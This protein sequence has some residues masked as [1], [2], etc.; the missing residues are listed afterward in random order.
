M[1]LLD[2]TTFFDGCKEELSSY[3]GHKSAAGI[4]FSF[5]K[6][7]EVQDYVNKKMEGIT[8][9]NELCYKVIPILENEITQKEVES[10]SMLAPF[11]NGFEEPLFLLENLKV[12]SPKRMGNGKHLKWVLNDAIDIVYFN[13]EK[14]AQYLSSASSLSF[15]ANLRINSFMGRKKINI[16]VAEAF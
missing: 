15:I 3:G 12:T 14:E 2:L 5:D 13:C 9:E 6:K 11:G 4:G 10:L 7:Q 8:F 16:F 1:G